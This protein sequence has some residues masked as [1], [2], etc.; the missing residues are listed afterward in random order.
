[1]ALKL[2]NHHWN[3]E[4]L[5]RLHPRGGVYTCSTEHDPVPDVLA[6]APELEAREWASH[7]EF[8]NA[9]LALTRLAIEMGRVVAFPAPRCNL[10]WIYGAGAAALPLKIIWTSPFNA[11][12]IPYARIGEGLSNLRC[13]GGNYMLE[14]CQKGHLSF[15]GGM[16]LPELDHF[17]EQVRLNGGGEATVPSSM[18]A[19]PPEGFNVVRLAHDLMKAY[20]GPSPGLFNPPDAPGPP[21]DVVAAGNA[22]GAK[23]PK[24]LWL[25][26]VP[27]LDGKPG[28][29]ELI[30]TEHHAKVMEFLSCLWLRGMP[31]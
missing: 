11:R 27:K 15:P 25:T 18:L 13:V 30:Y 19:A 14:G 21:E 3:W 23:R 26:E 1:M 16:I 29:R 6:F 2:A 28:P 10:S 17:V 8:D 9:S 22:P 24:V 5:H 4:L 7:E 20:G 31:W 12:V